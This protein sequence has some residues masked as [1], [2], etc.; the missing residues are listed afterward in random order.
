V[1]VALLLRIATGFFAVELLCLFFLFLLF[2]FLTRG[3]CF[4]YNAE[5]NF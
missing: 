1:G 3:S 5:I 4:W 2:S